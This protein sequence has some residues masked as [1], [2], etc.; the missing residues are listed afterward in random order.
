MSTAQLNRNATPSLR[1][2][3]RLSAAEGVPVSFLRAGRDATL[4]LQLGGAE[5]MPKHPFT[6]VSNEARHPGV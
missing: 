4:A 3:A 1:P 2:R 6:G 5:V